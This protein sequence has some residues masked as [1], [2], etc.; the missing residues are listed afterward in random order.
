MADNIE[1]SMVLVGGLAGRY[2]YDGVAANVVWPVTVDEL[3][4]HAQ[5]THDLD[6]QLLAD[7]VA[8]ATEEIET[9]GQVALIQQERRL[10]LNRLPSEESIYIPR[11]PLVSVTEIGYLDS[12]GVE[13]VL[14]TSYYSPRTRGRRPSVYFENTAGITPAEGDSVCWIDVICGYG[15]TSAS[16]AAQWRRL[17]LAVAAHGYERREMVSGGGLDAAMEAV[18]DRK[19]IAAGGSR[20]YV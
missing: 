9:R 6:D 2:P 5:I 7:L 17:I 1:G 12:A 15:Q 11:Q 10:V 20:R 8:D 3:K 13:Q 16:V 14:A 4:A 18:I 19:I